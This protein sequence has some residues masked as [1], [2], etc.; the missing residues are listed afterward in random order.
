MSLMI[1]TDKLEGTAKTAMEAKIQCVLA[2][3]IIAGEKIV[4]AYGHVS[5]RNPENP[6]SFFISRSI[7]PEFVTLDDL[8]EFDFDGNVLTKTEHRSYGERIIHARIF[9]ARP[10]VNAV[11]HAHPIEL[12]PFCCSNTPFKPINH[13]ASIF[14]RDIPIFNDLD[15]DAGMLIATFEQGE[16]LAKCLGDNIACLIRN[17]G[18]VVACEN[19]QQLMYASLVL[20]EGAE[21]LWR[22]LCMGAKPNYLGYEEAEKAAKLCFASTGLSR[23]WDY[24][25]KKA[26]GRFPDIRDLG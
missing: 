12:F 1:A 13:S 22:T 24:L 6:E 8:L 3:R 11:V 25:V 20:K 10:D 17:H 21:S 16:S 4:D 15:V 26:K 18:V 2:N 14:Y 7:S 19:I 23:S 5:L 9:N